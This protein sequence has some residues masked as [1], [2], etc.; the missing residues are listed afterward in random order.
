MKERNIDIWK[1]KLDWIAQ[2][3]G[4]ALINTHPDY[5]NFNESKISMEE[6]PAQL[7]TDFLHYIT[8]AYRGKFWHVLPKNLARFWQLNK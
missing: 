8:D 7:Y 3:R 4:M 2:K 5:M 1:K 6:Y